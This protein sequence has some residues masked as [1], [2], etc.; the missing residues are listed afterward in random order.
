[1]P[2]RL[3]SEGALGAAGVGDDRGVGSSVSVMISI[4]I[5]CPRA[6]NDNE[7]TL[8]RRRL[9]LTSIYKLAIVLSPRHNRVARALKH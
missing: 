4:L 1:M 9:E 7:Q 2:S 3:R 8:V 5:R 6:V